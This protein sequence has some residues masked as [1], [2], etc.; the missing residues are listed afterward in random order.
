VAQSEPIARTC[1]RYIETLLT[2]ASELDGE[3]GGN[4]RRIWYRG[5]ADA[6]WKLRPTLYRAA[7]SSEPEAVLAYEQKLR[8]AFMLRARALNP[9]I[10]TDK[11]DDDH[12]WLPLMQ[13]HGLPTRLLDWT[14]SSLV[15]LYF[16]V[17]DPGF[18][19]LDGRVWLINALNFASRPGEDLRT[20]RE[21]SRLVHLRE[22]SGYEVEAILSAQTNPRMYA[23][24]G[25]FMAF[26]PLSKRLIEVGLENSH[27]RS[28]RVSATDKNALRAGLLDLGVAS[29][30]LFPDF[31]H[32]ASSIKSEID[33]ATGA[34]GL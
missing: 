23:Q 27:I 30:M 20:A 5:H 33:S 34:L 16:A 8:D 31:D 22:D 32:L 24:R 7:P 12:E 3:A 13:H 14:E 1:A 19:K 28:I 10:R 15:A 29:H 4:V 25:Q 9:P 26:T 18:D 11:D 21:A 2:V 6:D 17:C